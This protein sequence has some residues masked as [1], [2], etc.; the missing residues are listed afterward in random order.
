MALFALPPV[1]RLFGQIQLQDLFAS[2]TLS[3]SERRLLA[4]ER[5]QN[6]LRAQE[7]TP[8]LQCAWQSVCFDDGVRSFS[9]TLHGRVK[10]DLNNRAF[11]RITI[12]G[13]RQPC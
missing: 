5:R 10:I 8:L 7:H 3:C 4:K 13:L 12:A 6:S 1:A 11:C 9:A 2:V